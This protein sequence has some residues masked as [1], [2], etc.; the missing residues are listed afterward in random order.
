MDTYTRYWWPNPVICAVQTSKLHVAYR[1]AQDFHMENAET[2]ISST[3]RSRSS[4]SWLLACKAATELWR[5]VSKYTLWLSDGRV[6]LM[7][8]LCRKKKNLKN[9]SCTNLC[10]CSEELDRRTKETRRLQEE[11]ET[12]TREALE[13]FGCTYRKCSPAQTV[14]HG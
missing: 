2:W 3:N 1:L 10:F 9:D 7:L 11:V 6:D 8:D 12:E 14:C 13:K 5:H 4:R